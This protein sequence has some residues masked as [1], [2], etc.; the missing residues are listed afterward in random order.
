MVIGRCDLPWRRNPSQSVDRSNQSS[1]SALPGTVQQGLSGSVVPMKNGVLLVNLGTPDAPTTRDVRRYLRQFLSDPR[2]LTLPGPLRW[3]L[4]NGV[5]LPTRPRKSAAAYRAIWTTTGS[6]L[7][8]HSEALTREVQNRLGERYAV[9]LGMRYGE[10]SIATA[11]AELEAEG[12]DRLI[13]LPLFPQ[14]A[15]AVTA[16]VSAE[17]FKS[18]SRR[19]DIP[20]VDILGAFYHEPDFA[21]AWAAAAGPG[22]REFN[23]DHVLFSFHGLPANQI[24]ASDPQQ[25]HCLARPDCCNAPGRSLS[26]CYRAQCFATADSLIEALDLDATRTTTCFQSRLGNTP[27]IGPYTDQVLGDLYAKGVRRMAVLCPAFVADC[28]ETVEEI[29]I[30]LRNDW[31]AL[32]GDELW[33]APCPN[34]DPRFAE[35]VAGWIRRRASA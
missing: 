14:Y 1:Q 25:G 32:G 4:L 13:V 19:V 7:R 6:P 35:A 24:R 11:L 31:L 20:P 10:P 22:L 27:W 15:S 29:G 16:S 12:I 8:I 9:R 3:L 17:V 2:V 33:L 18:L 21:A 23:A 5:I 28:L 30:R 26:R 34:A